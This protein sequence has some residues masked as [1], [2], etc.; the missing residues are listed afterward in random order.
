MFI[1]GDAGGT[2]TRAVAIDADWTC[3]RLRPGRRRESDLR[4]DRGGRRGD[5]GGGR[6]GD[7]RTRGGRGRG[8]GHRHGRGADRCVHHPADRA[9]R[10]ARPGAGGAAARPVGHVPLGHLPARGL[11]PDRRHRQHRRPDPR[12]RAAPGGRRPGLAARRRRQRLLDRASGGAGRG[13]GAGRAGAGDGADPAGAGGAGDR[14]TGSERPAVRRL[15]SALYARRPV[16]LAEF[17]PLAFALRR[18]SGRPG[19][20][21]RRQPRRWPTC[22][23]PSASPG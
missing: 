9:P 4:G 1:A 10:P 21:D 14:R 12:R 15:V 18:G 19:H 16:Q 3:S 2:S 11:R 13:R 17:A 7:G 23:A 22:C 20:P 5:R 6:A 8:R